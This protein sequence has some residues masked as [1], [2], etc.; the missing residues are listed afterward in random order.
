MKLSDIEFRAMDSRVA[1]VGT[2]KFRNPT[3]STNGTGSPEQG[4]FGDRL[5][6]RSRRLSVES[7]IA[8][9]LCGAGCDGRANRE[10][11]ETLP[12]IQVSRAGRYGVQVNSLTQIKMW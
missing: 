12:A 3:I 4:C 9:Q 6:K 10:S 1:Q 5:W 11:S 7:E 8:Q 2:E